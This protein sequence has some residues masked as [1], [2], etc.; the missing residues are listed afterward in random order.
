KSRRTGPDGRCNRISDETRYS[1]RNRDARL[2]GRADPGC[3]QLSDCRWTEM[4]RVQHAERHGGLL[5]RGLHATGSCARPGDRLGERAHGAGAAIRLFE[6]CM[7]EYHG[8]SYKVRV[9]IIATVGWLAKYNGQECDATFYENGPQPQ[10][11][12]EQLTPP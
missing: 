9:R 2:L 11:D 4:P 5:A 10:I 7:M 1:R 3:C 8:R 6:V 12:T